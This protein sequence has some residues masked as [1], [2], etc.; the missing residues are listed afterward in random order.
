MARGTVCKIL[1]KSAFARELG[2]YFI[3][4]HIAHLIFKI[5]AANKF[6]DLCSMCD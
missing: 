6:L 4:S 1:M 2:C 5:N 3:L